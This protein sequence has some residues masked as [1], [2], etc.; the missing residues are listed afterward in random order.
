M[1]IYQ[2]PKHIWE[3]RYTKLKKNKRT[4]GHKR[5]L[6]TQ[7]L[8]IKEGFVY[9]N[10]SKHLQFVSTWSYKHLKKVTQLVFIC[11]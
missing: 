9:T 4:Y 11:L 8:L 3:F 2:A 5:V 1:N 7:I 6:I 10:N